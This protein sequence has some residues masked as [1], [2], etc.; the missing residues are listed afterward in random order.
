[1][2]VVNTHTNL[3]VIIYRTSTCTLQIVML[4]GPYVKL[5]VFS[6][7]QMEGYNYLENKLGK[8]V[9]LNTGGSIDKYY[10]NQQAVVTPV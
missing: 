10:D 8:E 6:K 3:S 5:L 1:M 9:V 7:C 2:T 4:D